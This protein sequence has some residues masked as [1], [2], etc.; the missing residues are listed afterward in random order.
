MAWRVAYSL[1]TI[2]AQVDEAAPNRSKAADGTI[3]DAAH[4]S[5]TSDHNPDANGVVR[6]RDITHDPANGADMHALT[7]ALRLSR[8]PRI[9]YVI[10]NAR[11][12]SSYATSTFP[13]WAWRPYSGSNLHLKHAHLSVVADI[14]ADD[15]S[16]WTITTTPEVSMYLP[17][18]KAQNRTTDVAL[19]ALMLNDAFELSLPVDGSWPTSLENAITSHLGTTGSSKDGQFVIA[20][21]YLNLQRAFAAKHGG[22]GSVGPAGPPGPPGPQGPA[23]ARGSKGSKGDPGPSPKSATFT[24]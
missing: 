14:R 17:I 13:A 2:L 10:W 12:F 16:D 22:G 5:R 18:E 7:E 23:G 1:M 24:Y 21:Q 8:D 9:K 3:G 6:A 4:S 20:S 19:L 15:T 11:M